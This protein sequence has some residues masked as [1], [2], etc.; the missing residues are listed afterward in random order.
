MNLDEMNL[1]AVVGELAKLDEEVRNATDAEFVIKAAETKKDLLTRKNELEDLEQRKQ[2][3]LDISVQKIEPVIIERRKEDNME[4]TFAIDSVEYRNAWL[5]AMKST[6]VSEAEQRALTG[7]SYLVPTATANKILDSLVDMVP[8]LNE[9]DLLRVKGNVTFAVNTVAPTVSIKAG[10]SAVDEAAT[11]FVQVSLGSYTISTIVRIGA[12]TASMAIDAFEGWLIGKIAEQLS[13][14]IENYIIN[15]D[16]DGEPTGIDLAYTSSA[17]ADT[18]DAVDWAST[19]LGTGDIDEAIG[20]L[21]AVYDRNAKFLMSKKTFFQSVIGLQDVNNVPLVSREEGKY[22]IRG[23]EVI[24]SDQVT[25]GDIFYGDFKRGMVG[26]LSNEV[27]VE[28]DRNL[29]YNAWD[30][31]GW[32]SFDCKPSKVKAIIKIAADIA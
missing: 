26:N 8:L 9:I 5:N 32:C 23:Y 27:Q 7:A 2:A 21:P 14:K 28:R 29:S 18:T 30:Y 6:Q 20:M 4:K 31:L 11:T 25:T 10:G 15:G 12:D 13:Y 16:G 3:A 1:E 17:W 24:F 22:R 19:A